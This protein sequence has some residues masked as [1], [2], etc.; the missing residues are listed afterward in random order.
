MSGLTLALLCG[1]AAVVF[2]AGSI[3]WIRKRDPGNARRQEIAAAI[4]QGAQAYLS[5][6]YRTIAMVGVALAVLIA[7]VL[8]SGVLT[9]AGFV[10][11]A[12]LSG[13]AGFIGMTVSVRAKVRISPA[14]PTG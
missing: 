4:Q 10:L 3:S 7:A 14:H 1:G 13:A 11:G 5:R 9:A 8:P 6:Q 2:G 12:V